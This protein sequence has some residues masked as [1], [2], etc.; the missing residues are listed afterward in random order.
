MTTM[1]CICG[2]FVG[3]AIGF[4]GIMHLYHILYNM[5]TIEMHKTTKEV[6]SYLYLD[7]LFQFTKQM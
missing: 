6:N 2:I 5:T 7:E 1:G 3:A 4:L